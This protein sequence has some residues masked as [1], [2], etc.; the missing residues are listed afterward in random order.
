MNKL[1]EAVMHYVHW[2]EAIGLVVF[3][4]ALDAIVKPFGVVVNALPVVG[5]IFGAGFWA[6]FVV[7]LVAGATLHWAGDMWRGGH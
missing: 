4:V 5:A 6:P 1:F 3:L 7:L 2:Q